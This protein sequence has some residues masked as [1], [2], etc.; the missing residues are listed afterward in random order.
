MPKVIL[1]HDVYMALKAESLVRNSSLKD[2]LAIM[3]ISNLSPKAKSVLNVLDVKK[4]LL[5]HRA[6][7]NANDFDEEMLPFKKKTRTP[8]MRNPEA[9]ATVDEMLKQHPTV[10]YA[11][12]G[13]AVGYSRHVIGDYHKKKLKEG[14]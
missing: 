12:I 8:L 10:T 1:D 3:V 7:S 14:Q 4:V 13:K 5:S 6:S 9:V 2:T 11:E